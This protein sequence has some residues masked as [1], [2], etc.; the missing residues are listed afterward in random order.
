MRH[1][2]SEKGS[3]LLMTVITIAV[4]TVLGTTI[5]SLSLMNYNMKFTDTMMKRT[6]YYSESGI[7]Q[8]YSILGYYVDEALK[9]ASDETALD[10]LQKKTVME[11]ILS[12][13]R[14]YESQLMLDMVYLIEQNVLYN[15]AY[16]TSTTPSGYMNRKLYLKQ[17]LSNI[18]ATYNLYNDYSS[19]LYEGYFL[20]VMSGTPDHM[21]R[22]L[23]KAD[24]YS[25]HA[26]HTIVFD[27]E[28][29]TRYHNERMNYHFKEYFNSAVSAIEAD[30]K[31]SGGTS[32]YIFLDQE[33]TL[34]NL[35]LE[36]ID[37]SEILDF[38]ETDGHALY[39][40]QFVVKELTSTFTFHDR[41]QRTISTDLVIEA[42][43]DMM[44]IT[45]NQSKYATVDNPLWQYA[46]VTEKDLRFANVDAVIIGNMYALGTNPTGDFNLDPQ[47]SNSP[48]NTNNYKGVIVAGQDNTI[49]VSGDVVTQSFVQM[50]AGTQN[51]HL[52]V[53]NG[54]I[55]CDSLAIQSD[56]RHHIIGENN[57]IDVIN[58][59]VYTKND[60]I[61][62]GKGNHI[63]IDGNYYGFVGRSNNYHQLSS[64]VINADIQRGTGTSSLNITGDPPKHPI[65]EESDKEGIFIAGTSFV[66]DT[67]TPDP[68]NGP[69]SLYETGESMGIRGNYLAYAFPISDTSGLAEGGAGIQMATPAKGTESSLQLYYKVDGASDVMSVE[70]KATYFT[71]ISQ[72]ASVEP[73]IEKGD[74][75]INI[76]HDAYIFTQGAV[77]G[78]S[79][80]GNQTID[81][82]STNGNLMNNYAETEILRDYTYILNYLRHRQAQGDPIGFYGD[83]SNVK[84]TIENMKNARVIGNYSNIDQTPTADWI[85]KDATIEEVDYYTVN[86]GLSGDSQVKEV[87]IFQGTS[88]QQDILLI[89]ENPPA[90]YRGLSD[91][92]QTINGKN[93]YVINTTDESPTQMQGVVITSGEVTIVGDMTYY[94][95]IIAQENIY[96]E[97]ASVDIINNSMDVRNY[98]TQLIME[99]PKLSS[100]FNRDTLNSPLGI[101]L[102]QM[103]VIE[104]ILVA[105]GDIGEMRKHYEEYIHIKNWRIA[106]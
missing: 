90:Q 74:G 81:V 43:K 77:M 86:T 53:L 22:V 15:G 68:N 79:A 44:P 71:Q 67:F 54:H 33:A 18:H 32:N 55:Y 42:P 66:N 106:Q 99:T 88:H 92:L 105:P 28:A 11:N 8:V 72:E 38:S 84:D 101:E 41:T 103:E 96:I 91:G 19:G 31:S 12:D 80:A 98:L 82:H 25:D 89:G 40:N 17:F 2:Q 23:T 9:Y 34:G 14:S 57:R 47:N 59:N 36:S 49:S 10:V 39:D 95:T 69:S 65:E 83:T 94:G 85:G 100:A 27:Q 61:L 1:L 93:Y 64:I 60:L 30:I 26:Y 52:S 48:R 37:F 5:L 75:N 20:K 29:M 87:A 45:V 58:G 51:S 3:T 78:K 56:S 76:D 63:N 62:N 13:I 35:I 70:D 7:D 16:S 104:E 46:L 50:E 21:T 4:L 24:D 73:F 102:N 97:N 6:Q